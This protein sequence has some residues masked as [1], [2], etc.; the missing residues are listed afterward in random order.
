MESGRSSFK[1]GSQGILRIGECS[2]VKLY[3]LKLLSAKCVTQKRT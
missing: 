2:T 3:V 1:M